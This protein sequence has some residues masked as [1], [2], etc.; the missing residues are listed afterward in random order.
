MGHASIGYRLAERPEG[1]WSEPIIFYKP[2][3]KSQKDFIYSAN[4]HPEITADG[5]LI[6]YNINNSDFDELIKNEEIYFP[7]LIKIKLSK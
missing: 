2:H 3:L 4:A 5:I 7:K 1:P 6:T